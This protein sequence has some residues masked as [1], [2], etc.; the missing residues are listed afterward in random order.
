L[1]LLA[2]NHISTTI[3]TDLVDK[4]TQWKE[5]LEFEN[6]QEKESSIWMSSF[7]AQDSWDELE[8]RILDDINCMYIGYFRTIII[9]LCTR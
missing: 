5:A 7:Y 2:I 3:R 6:E 1:F 9:D 8:L 4:I